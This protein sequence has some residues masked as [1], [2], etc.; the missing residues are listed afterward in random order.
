MKV[1][2]ALYRIEQLEKL[3]CNLEKIASAVFNNENLSKEIAEKAEIFGETPF[4]I[5]SNAKSTV[6]EEIERI[7]NAMNEVEFDA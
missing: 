5:I 4:F 2:D 1:R 3:K 6:A 7:R